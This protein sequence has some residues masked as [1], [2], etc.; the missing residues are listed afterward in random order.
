MT[1]WFDRE[2]PPMTAHSLDPNV[3]RLVQL[4]DDVSRIASTLAHLSA[5]G[6]SADVL[7]TETTPDEVDVALQRVTAFIRMRA[8]REHFFPRELFADPAWD[9]LLGAFQAELR[10][11]RMSVSDLCLV[12]AVPAS[13]ALRWQTSMVEQGMFV[14]KND[15]L[16]G[17]RVFIE[18]SP[19]A[20]SSLR[21]FF[22]AMPTI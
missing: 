5:E 14:R 17:R 16:D 1:R 19:E 20:S 15:P 6:G 9:M 21:R 18:L 2:S 11:R 8:M 22:V 10:Q 12:A 13:T 4:N 7:T 3:K